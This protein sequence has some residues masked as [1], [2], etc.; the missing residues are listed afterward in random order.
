MQLATALMGD[1]WAADPQAALDQLGQRATELIA[2]NIAEGIKA[3]EKLIGEGNKSKQ[4]RDAER[5]QLLDDLQNEFK[6]FEESGVPFPEAARAKMVELQ[7]YFKRTFVLPADEMKKIDEIMK[8]AAENPNMLKIYAASVWEKLVKLHKTTDEAIDGFNNMLD[9]M[10]NATVQHLR[11]LGDE[12]LA[13]G[14]A[15]SHSSC[16]STSPASTRSSTRAFS[17]GSAR[18]PPSRPSTWARKG[19]PIMTP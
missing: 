3:R 5:K 9:F 10:D 13:H 17:A 15:V 11:T 14:R 16:P 8:R 18:A 7:N 19:W 4:E 1:G 6:V 2:H 12:I